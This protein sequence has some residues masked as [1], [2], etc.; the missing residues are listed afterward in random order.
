NWIRPMVDSEPLRPPLAPHS[1][2]LDH[3]K[4]CTAYKELA[5]AAALHF[6]AEH[7][8]IPPE[9]ALPGGSKFM[10]E[11]LRDDKPKARGRAS[12]Y[13]ARILVVKLPLAP[14]IRKRSSVIFL[15]LCK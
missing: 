7:K 4:N 13:L 9:W 11:L 5:A 2:Y 10:C 8:I 15:S 12:N 14:P 6:C 3:L 1:R